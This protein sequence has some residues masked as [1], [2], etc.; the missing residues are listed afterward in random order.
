MF[1][2][3]YLHLD[4]VIILWESNNWAYFVDQSFLDSRV[5]YESLGVFRA[6]VGNLFG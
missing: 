6:G 4:D 1:V 2:H 5:Q 3:I